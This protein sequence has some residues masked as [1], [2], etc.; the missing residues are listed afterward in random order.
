MVH[1]EWIDGCFSISHS[2]LHPCGTEQ[3]VPQALQTAAI[4][5]AYQK[6]A[7]ISLK[8]KEPSIAPMSEGTVTKL[9]TTL[10]GFIDQIL[11]LLTD[12]PIAQEVQQM[13]DPGHSLHVPARC[14]VW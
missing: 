9:S 14:S 11:S 10:E 2:F 12:W 13:E 6:H 8:L 7:K 4:K 3:N 5:D 1:W